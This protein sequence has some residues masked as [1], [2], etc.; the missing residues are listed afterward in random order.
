MR[1]LWGGAVH[2]A[3]TSDF[4]AEKDVLGHAQSFKDQVLLI[5]Y[6][7]SLFLNLTGPEPPQR[8]V[9][10]KDVARVRGL[11]TAHTVQ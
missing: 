6:R 7:H 1:G 10:D 9:P 3:A 11:G 5:D 8:R 2:P 4:V